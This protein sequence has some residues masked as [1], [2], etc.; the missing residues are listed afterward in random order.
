MLQLT[1]DLGARSYP[2]H[3]GAALLARPELFATA[4][5]G[6]K[7]LIITNDRI[8][9]LY[10]QSLLATLANHRAEVCILPDGEQYKTVESAMQIWDRLI[11]GH[12]DRGTTLLALGGGV[13]GDLT[14][15]AA[16]CYQ[17]GVDFVQVPT[18]LL[19]QVD[20]SVGGK[21]GVNHPQGKNMIGAFHQPRAVII[22][23]NTLNT[24]APREF[25]AGLAE[26]IKYGLLGDADFFGWLEANME[27]LM[28]RDPDTVAR[29]IEHS[30]RAKALIV[31]ADETEQGQRALLNLG[32][33]FGHA[34]ESVTHYR[35]W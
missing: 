6:E 14:G 2:I 34:I 16:A 30:C 25:S 9:P 33:T 31:M 20:S 17:R 1:V 10:L 7:V 35:R 22:D 26:V 24:L 19:A 23:T 11:A 32:H 21:T 13:I 5:R 29:A 27:Q 3:I 18:T 12:H 15:F 4:I 28:A 8:A